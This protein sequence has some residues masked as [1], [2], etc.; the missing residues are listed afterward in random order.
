MYDTY[1]DYLTLKNRAYYIE[2]GRTA[3]IQMLH[4]IYF[5]IKYKYWVF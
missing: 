5:F 2:E 4:F 3:T 1:Y